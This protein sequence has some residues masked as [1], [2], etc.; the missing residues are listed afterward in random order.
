[1]RLF[2]HQ[3]INSTLPISMELSTPSLKE[4]IEKTREALDIAYSGFDN[5]IEEEL[6]DSYIYEINALLKKYEHLLELATL[7]NME[8]PEILNQ[9]SPIRS[10]V[11][12]V[13][14]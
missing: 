6:I 9:H 13:L 2:Y 11:S 7:E 5:A 4:S 14:G 3:K 12:Q 8:Y 10:L 1:M